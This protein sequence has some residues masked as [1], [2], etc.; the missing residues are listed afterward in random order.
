MSSTLGSRALCLCCTRVKHWL[1]HCSRLWPK[2]MTHHWQTVSVQGC[3]DESAPRRLPRPCAMQ[4]AAGGCPVSAAA[5]SHPSSAHPAP[6]WHRS[7]CSCCSAVDQLAVA[8][9]MLQL[10][11][12][13]SVPSA[14]T[15]AWYMLACILK[16]AAPGARHE[17]NKP[18]A[19][20]L[21]CAHGGCC[22]S[23]SK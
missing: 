12:V 22:D 2:Y 8:V 9:G 1:E 16:C 17:Q 13:D 6:R 10:A 14:H 11:V 23:S 3:D 19:Q 5:I 20:H 21:L 15:C 4:T 7:G 18:H